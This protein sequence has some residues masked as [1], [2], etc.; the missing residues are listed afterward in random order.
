MPN[1]ARR[2]IEPD[3]E[4]LRKLGEMLK[5]AEAT[6]RDRETLY[7][8][9]MVQLSE[10]QARVRETRRGLDSA[11]DVV[12]EIMDQIDAEKVGS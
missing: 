5:S 2:T 10:A 7:N 3:A 12:S 11:R 1:H 8:N 4:V 6:V 9:A